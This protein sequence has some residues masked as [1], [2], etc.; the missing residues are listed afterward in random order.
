[1]TGFTL[2]GIMLILMGIILVLLGIIMMVGTNIPWI[3][4]LPG[5][6]IIKRNILAFTFPSPPVSSSVLS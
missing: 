6:I 5:D 2:M 3:G 4:R 1:M